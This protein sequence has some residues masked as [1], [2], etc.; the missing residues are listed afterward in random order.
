M[1]KIFL[2]GAVCAVII[3]YFGLTKVPASFPVQQT[4]KIDNNLSTEQIG[5][6]LKEKKV[7]TSPFLFKFIAKN[8]KAGEYYFSTKESIFSIVNR[9]TEGKGNLP[10]A[11][12]TIPEGSN[13]E[14]IAAIIWGKVP[15]FDAPQFI[16]KAKKYQG[17]LFPDTYNISLTADED[18][19]ISL[20]RNTFDKKVGTTTENMVRMAAILEEEGKTETDR[21]MISDILWR[22]LSIG[23]PLQ[24]DVAMETYKT[25]GFPAL[26][27]TN[28]GLESIQAALNPTKNNYLYY[29]TGNNGIFHYARTYE[30]H[31][32]N[33]QKYLKN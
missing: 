16:K 32:V 23:M 26:P 17:R 2:L 31:L 13:N 20:L 15:N 21:K 28:P 9:L 10:V 29:I 1:K 30:E 3:V 12:I 33:I 11:K 4:I 18:V 6:Y 27:I 22:R 7:I 8:I 25:K 24:V 19:V 14:Q 5:Q